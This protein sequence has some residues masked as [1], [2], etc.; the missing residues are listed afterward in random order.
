VGTKVKISVLAPTQTASSAMDSSSL[1]RVPNA[2]TVASITNRV[3]RIHEEI[4]IESLPAPKTVP[5][6]GKISDSAIDNTKEQ[7]QDTI[8]PWHKITSKSLKETEK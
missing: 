3:Y 7:G 8:Q 6:N 2:R 4:E 5:T 1:G